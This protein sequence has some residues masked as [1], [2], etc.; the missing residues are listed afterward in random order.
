MGAEAD[1]RPGAAQAAASVETPS[2]KGAGDENFPVGS[3]LLPRR[4]RPH[5]AIFYAFARAID[6]IA[7]NPMLAPDDKIRRLDAF[8][9]A[10]YARVTGRP[11]LEKAYRVRASCLEM[12]VPLDH[13]RDLIAAFKQDA[14]KLRYADWNDLMGYCYLSAA[15]VGRFLLDLHGEARSG[16]P[17]SDAGGNALQVLNH[18]QDCAD[19]YRNLD[20]VYLP[21]DWMAAEGET[22]AALDRESCSPALRKVL[23]RT[24]AA[25]DELLVAAR[26][27]PHRLRSRGLAMESAV[28]LRL[29]LRLSARLKRGDPLA[30]RVALDKLDFVQCGVRGAVAGL[31]R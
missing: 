26:E 12:G 6:D 13:C 10:L 14:V 5:V 30:R 27:L 9:D 18:L 29:A 8:E 2:G 17:A 11:S 22:V 15:P 19:D 25:T 4:L 24:I 31:V 1:M 16:F 28:I 23:D 20:R 3:F 21:L 7:D